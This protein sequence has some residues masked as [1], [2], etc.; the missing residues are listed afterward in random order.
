MPAID[1]E[2]IEEPGDKA[3][4]MTKSCVV[5]TS[6]RFTFNEEYKSACS[7]SERGYSSHSLDP[8]ESVNDGPLPDPSGS[9]NDG[10]LDPSES[11]DSRDP[12]EYVDNGFPD[13]S[14]SVDN[15]TGEG[16][17]PDP[18]ILINCVRGSRGGS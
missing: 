3:M 1:H 6:A 12:S 8:S 17:R 2:K 14:E 10:L 4:E 5:V 15:S 16:V 13:P 11:V 18:G 7:A 9:V